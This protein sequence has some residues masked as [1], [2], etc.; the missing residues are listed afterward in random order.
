MP[1]S[2]GQVLYYD[3]TKWVNSSTIVSSF[4]I[5]QGQTI[6]LTSDAGTNNVPYPLQVRHTS[7][8][9]AAV[10][11]GVGLQYFGQASDDSAVEI[12][13]IRAVES[14]PTKYS[15]TGVYRSYLSFGSYHFESGSPQGSILTLLLGDRNDTT[16]AGVFCAVP[17][18]G[19]GGS[20]VPFRFYLLTK[21]LSGVSSPYA[22]TN[23]EY[24]CP[25]IKFTSASAA[26]TITFPST[27]GGFWIIYNNSGQTLTLNP[28]GL[29]L[30]N[31]LHGIYF[32]DGTNLHQVATP[33]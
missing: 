7:S 29:T 19:F 1:L 25:I 23:N 12:A 8:G 6:C 26:M 30:N 13:T 32:A 31:N 2:A 10:G 21:S 17:V 11:F 22:L 16:G 15:T 27:A 28:G 5:I 24:Q 18:R 14:D 33:A 4:L 3:G 9:D 20:N